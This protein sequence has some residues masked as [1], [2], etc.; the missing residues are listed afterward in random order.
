M[1]KALFAYMAISAGFVAI[2]RTAEAHHGWVEFD[3]GVE[4]TM[5]G[6]V[7]DFHFTNP[8]CVVEFEVKDAKGK[9]RKWQGEFASP[10]ELVRKGWTAATLQPGDEITIT[11]HP[12]KDHGPAIHV[13]GIRLANGQELKLGYAK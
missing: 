6:T 10:P 3:E 2:P 13:S 9:V 11:G 5:P 1:K 7:I 8:H 4:V 12:S